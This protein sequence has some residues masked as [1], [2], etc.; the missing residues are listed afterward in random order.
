MGH[1]TSQT[2]QSKLIDPIESR[3][4]LNIVLDHIDIIG[5]GEETREGRGARVPHRCRDYAWD[6]TRGTGQQSLPR[7]PTQLILSYFLA[8]FSN[9]LPG[10]QVGTCHSE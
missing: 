5:G 3:W 2:V 8:I 6:R 9:I 10:K 4:I 1:V 7:D